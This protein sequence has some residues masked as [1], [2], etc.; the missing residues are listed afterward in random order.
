MSVPATPLQ[1]GGVSRLLHD[2]AQLL[3]RDPKAAA[4]EARAFLER[5]PS[6]RQALVLLVTAH[7]FTGDLASAR[8]ALLEMAE[9]GPGLAAVHYQLGLLLNETGEREKAIAALSRAVA[10]E[11]RLA[12]AW[13][14][15]GDALAECGNAFEANKAYAKCVELAAARLERLEQEASGAQSQLPRAE[16]MLRARLGRDPTDLSAL[17]LL[18]SVYLRLGRSADAKKPLRR[19][20]ELAPDFAP[21]KKL[22]ALSPSVFAGGVPPQ[23]SPS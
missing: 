15:L 1:P 6:Q 13:R 20:L 23:T 3:Q 18:G 9:A 5:H 8:A 11:P 17:V 4:V 10:L 22:A 12:Q 19:A 14:A 2:I 21:A 7:R 16:R